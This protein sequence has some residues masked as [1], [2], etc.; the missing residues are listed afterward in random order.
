MS[1][2]KNVGVF[3]EVPGHSQ[4]TSSESEPPSS[5]D[6]AG[7]SSAEL[8]PAATESGTS[9]PTEGVPHAPVELP[10]ATTA[11]VTRREPRWHWVLLGTFIGAP[12]GV[13]VAAAVRPPLV[14]ETRFIAFHEASKDALAS[15][16][17]PPEKTPTGDS[18]AW[19]A[20]KDCTLSLY[21]RAESD[22]AIGFLAAPFRYPGSPDQSVEVFLNDTSLGNYPINGSTIPV[23]VAPKEVWRRGANELRFSFAYAEAPKSHTDNP[24][25]RRLSA[26]FTWVAITGS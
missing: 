16:W 22:R 14:Q 8:H 13:V 26:S 12:I 11:S 18:F 21:S 2:S 9:N 25:P 24:D 7:P 19:C 20:S 17:S 6:T 5:P 1:D 15:G 3:P 23:A 10:L 4:P